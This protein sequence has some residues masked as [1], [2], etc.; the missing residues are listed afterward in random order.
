[1]PLR[2][3]IGSGRCADGV[4]S[5]DPNV[6]ELCQ[7]LTAKLATLQVEPA[8]R[9]RSLEPTNAE[10]VRLSDREG[11]LQTYRDDLGDGS[12]LI[13]IQGFV[14]SWRFPRYFG[15]AGVGHMY[16]EGVVVSTGGTVV[17]ADEKYLW[18]FR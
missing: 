1:M 3:A 10:H 9:L 12:C 6:R 7:C 4:K 2:I 13:V 15:G 16:A 8:E 14:A 11:I 5:G 18:E 17:P